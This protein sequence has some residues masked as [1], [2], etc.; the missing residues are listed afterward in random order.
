MSYYSFSQ[1]DKLF[2]NSLNVSKIL[3]T[4]NLIL[5]LFHKRVL[6]STPH[7]LHNSTATC[8]VILFS[9][10]TPPSAQWYLFE[11][12]EKSQK[13]KW[14]PPGQFLHLMY[15]F[16]RGQSCKI[17]PL[18]FPEGSS[19][20]CC[21]QPWKI[22][23]QIQSLTHAKEQ[24]SPKPQGVF[25]VWYISNGVY[26]PYHHRNWQNIHSLCLMQSFSKFT[27]FPSRFESLKLCCTV[28][29][30][31]VQV[32]GKGTF[33]CFGLNIWRQYVYC[34]ICYVLVPPSFT[35]KRDINFTG[36]SHKLR[37]GIQI[38]SRLA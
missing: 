3:L 15:Q 4:V 14:V 19:Y 31:N 28:T 33:G 37:R 8:C 17:F 1:E 11:N 36:K 18:I 21:I 13:H 2:K 22:P 38:T 35:I 32:R 30:F 6:R 24:H 23:L 7:T 26:F 29:A 5:D 34:Q 10:F 27:A 20:F 12:G 16:F 25:M 9:I